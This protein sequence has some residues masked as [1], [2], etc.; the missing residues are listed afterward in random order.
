MDKVNKNIQ[1]S[2][3]MSTAINDE[4]AATSSE[5][6]N[7]VEIG[8]NWLA[9]QQNADGSWGT[10][11]KVAVTGFAVLKLES[12]A[13]EQGF[14]SPLDPLYI[15]NQEVKNGLNYIFSQALTIPITVQPA[16]NPDTN[17]DGI[18]VYFGGG[19]HQ[20]YNAGI[21]LIA[22]A[23]SRIPNEIVNV[24]GSPVNTW[25][26]KQVAQ[27]VV[28]YLAWGQ[29]DFGSGRGGWNY[30]PHD[31]NGPRSDNSNSGWVTLGLAFAE[32]YFTN[33]IPQFVKDELNIWINYIQNDDNGG[34]GY[35]S[36]TYWVNI[37]KTGNLL[38]QME[39]YGDTAATTRVQNAINYIVT[40]WNDPN[41]D[42]GWRGTPTNYQATFTLMKG[43]ESLGVDI[44]NGIDWFD[45]ISTALVA[46]QNQD[47][48]SPNYGSWPS[49]CAW[50]NNILCTAWALLTL[51]KVTTPPPTRGI[52]L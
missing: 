10:A 32:F 40:H 45:E 31:N 18:G 11:E 14:D 6:E 49:T 37:L 48:A 21:A 25:T 8:V 9:G 7:A 34:S 43:L 47:P 35:D 44:I 51:E 13:I 46:E 5:I 22:I 27:D 23:A 26:F 41:P 2:L 42:P 20:I 19:A 1:S 15:Y 4:I 30:V 50:G 16:G 29:T 39:F 24:M 17:G 12:Y 33:T 36:P 52:M 3:T 38:Q 28:D